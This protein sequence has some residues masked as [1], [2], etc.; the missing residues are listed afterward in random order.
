M[1][2]ATVAPLNA[3][4]RN[5]F[6]APPNAQGYINYPVL[7]AAAYQRGELGKR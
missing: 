5:T 3:A 2:K 7:A 6:F 1:T 4:D